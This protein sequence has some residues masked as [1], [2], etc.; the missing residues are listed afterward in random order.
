[1]CAWVRPTPAR[2]R[3][4]PDRS[5]RSTRTRLP[6]PN[7]HADTEAFIVEIHEQLESDRVE[8]P[9]EVVRQGHP[10]GARLIGR[11]REPHSGALP[12]IP[13]RQIHHIQAE[14]HLEG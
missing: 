11:T 1:M 8:A 2:R 9:S 12:G 4:R 14:R 13:D 6:D 5:G 10:H 7:Q 3:A